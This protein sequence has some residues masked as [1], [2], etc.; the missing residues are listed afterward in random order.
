MDDEIKGY[1]RNGIIIVVCIIGG[2]GPFSFFKGCDDKPEPLPHIDNYPISTSSTYEDD[3]EMEDNIDEPE[4]TTIPSGEN[5]S[6]GGNVYYFTPNNQE[7]G[8]YN[9]ATDSYTN[10]SSS[11]EYQ[12][13]TNSGTSPQTRKECMFLYASDMAHCGGTGI[14]QRCGGDG[15]MDDMFGGGPNTIECSSCRGSGKCSTCHG[16]GFID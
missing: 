8:N 5:I 4:Q 13:N 6:S 10:Q 7:Y 16:T 3:Y 12:S 14:C 1:I 9:N 11:S 15:W 2:I